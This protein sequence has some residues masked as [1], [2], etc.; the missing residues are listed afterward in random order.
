[1]VVALL[2]TLFPT[3]ALPTTY[4]RPSD[5]SVACLDMTSGK[6][7]WRTKPNEF[8]PKRISVKQKVV[9]ASSEKGD[10]YLDAETGQILNNP[11]A[12]D[13]E[14]TGPLPPLEQNLKSSDGLVFEYSRGNTQGLIGRM[15]GTV[16]Y[17]KYLE[18]YP[19]DLH[20]VNN[21]AIFTFAGGGSSTGGG[22]VYAFDLKRNTLVWEFG[23]SKLLEGLAESETTNITVDGEKVLVSV[24]QVIFALSVD[25]G[26][27]L[28]MARLPRQSIR[29][30]DSAWTQIGRVG[31]TLFVQCYED[32]FALR[33]EDGKLLWSFDAGPFGES[34]PTIK[35]G[36]IY[37]ATRSG[38]VEMSSFSFVG[39]FREKLISAVKVTKDGKSPAG[40]SL[41]FISRRDIPKGEDV[42]WTL[43]P[44]PKVNTDVATSRLVLR[45]VAEY[46]WSAADVDLTVDLTQPLS[47]SGKAYV[48][49]HGFFEKAL[50]LKDNV[51]ILEVD[52][53]E[54][55]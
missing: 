21:L 40:Y 37:L 41:E 17:T 51:E 8:E 33:A 45:L 50:L 12:L 53:P 2:L 36:R 11:P 30:H 35:D 23:A 20:I 5:Y 3:R 22:E 10:Y 42:W 9:I 29:Q 7:L 25:S 13:A 6:L 46:K 55:P 47:A 19:Y 39:G 16:Q 31:K 38:P 1:M 24:D 14:E 44:P 4:L 26:E 15:N 34:W 49:F 18:D 43:K 54:E 28:W 48:K 52:K 27:V 32:L